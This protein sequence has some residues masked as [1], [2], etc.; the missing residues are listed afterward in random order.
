MKS[1]C[2][3]DSPIGRLRIAEDGTGIT[4]ITLLR[5]EAEATAQYETEL[6]K[7]AVRQLEEYFAGR[8]KEFDLPLSLKGTP[9]QLSVWEALRTIPYGRTCSYQQ[10][11]AQVGNAKA[12]RAVGMANNRNPVMIVVPCHR[13]IG[14]N[15]AMVGFGCGLE[16][17]EYLLGL[18]N[19]A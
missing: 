1:I 14:K 2:Y 19:K 18:E 15:G 16:V 5:S 12:C 17:K 8:R 6:L 13:V 4:E 3:Y 9:F 7:T 11:A 10:I